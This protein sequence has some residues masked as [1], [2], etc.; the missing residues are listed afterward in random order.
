MRNMLHNFM[1]GRYGPDHLGIAMIVFSFVL[2]ILY[3]ILGVTPVLYISYILFGL[4]LYRMLSRN[5]HRRRSENDTF[6]RY[7]WPIRIKIRHTVKKIKQRMTH[8]YFKC[9]TCKSK[10]RVPK[11][12]GKLRVTCNKCGE[13]LFMKS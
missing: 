1:M 11:G 6:I 7:W 9:P 4:T 5:L 3:A 2:S 10:L 13:K 12:I 8:K